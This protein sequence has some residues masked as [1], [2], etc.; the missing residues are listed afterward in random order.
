M[1]DSQNCSIVRG[2][3]IAAGDGT[4]LRAEGY[5]VS[6]PM[7]PVGGRPLI[8]RTL[9]RFRAVGIRQLSI[10]I[11]Q[12]SDD[13]RRWLYEHTADFEI[14]LIVSSTQSSYASFQIVA[15]RLLGAPALISTVDAVM[16]ASDFRA[17]I[18]SALNLPR[19]AVALALTDHIDDDI[20]LWA[21][22]DADGRI[23]QLGGSEG[24]H[25]T[26]GLYWLPKERPAEPTT[27]FARLRDY[28]SWLIGQHQPV[29]GIVL[30]RVFDID[31]ARDI[32]AAEASEFGIESGMM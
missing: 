14:D 18:E 30:P 7:V 29:C 12:T 17:F 27:S 13:C 3:V 16:P 1:I 21:T 31:R 19:N 32:A 11:N 4:R 2:G 24:S 8:D 25:V 28:L 23:R 22:M 20:P 6:K 10:I 5:R 9:H 15:N 26:A